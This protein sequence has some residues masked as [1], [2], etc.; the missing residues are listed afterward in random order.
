MAPSFNGGIMSKIIADKSVLDYCKKAAPGNKTVY[1]NMDAINEL[2]DQ[3]EVILSEVKFDIKSEFSEVGGKKLMPTT[4]LMYRIAEATGISGGDNSITEP[5]VEEVDINPLMMKKIGEPATLRKMVVGRKVKKYSTLLQEDGTLRKS[6][7]CTS[8]FNVWERCL[9]LWT[10]EE[11][12]TEG[13]SKKGKYDNKYDSSYKRNAHFNKEMKFAHA[14]AE[15]KA[16]CKTIRELA[17][18]MTGYTAVDLKEGKFIFSRVRKSQEALKLEQAANL[19][20]IAGGAEAA[21]AGNLLFGATEEGITV[22]PEVKVEE[23]DPFDD[24][25][26]VT[27]TPVEELLG[28]FQ[29]YQKIIKDNKDMTAVVGWLEKKPEDTAANYQRGWDKAI[30]ILKEVEKKVDLSELVEHKFY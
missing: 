2:P 13:Y 18:L 6:S 29:T 22:E 24:M 19:S 4:D 5:V 7:A 12:Y 25:E 9:E 28:I 3:F 8:I 27:P 1:V 26:D 11:M 23:P 15:S 30:G 21:P 20:R 10:T 14:K 16:H 17:G